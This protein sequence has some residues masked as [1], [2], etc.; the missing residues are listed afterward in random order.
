MV[1]PELQELF[2]AFTA[3]PRAL[4][5]QIAGIDAGGMNQRPPGSDWSIRDVLHHLTDHELVRGVQVRMILGA[6]EPPPIPGYDEARWQRRLQ[7]LWRSP[8]AALSLFEQARYVT[9][10]LLSHCDR[11]AWQRTGIHPERGPQTVHDLVEGLVTHTATHVEQ[12]R[13]AREALTKRR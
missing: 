12:A 3:G 4:R 11:T 13:A 2:R 1:P 5:E 6:E 7:Y 10:E 8:E 9:A